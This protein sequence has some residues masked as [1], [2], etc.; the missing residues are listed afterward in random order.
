MIDSV[1]PEAAATT[2]STDADA[3]SEARVALRLVR[4]SLV[5]LRRHLDLESTFVTE[6]DGDEVVVRFL[7]GDDQGG[8]LRV[9]GRHP[10]SS[11][12]HPVLLDGSGPVVAPDL[13]RNRRWSGSY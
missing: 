10:V 5:T 8:R 9:G 2:A 6:H 4:S 11:P 7:D 1:P 12:H 13:R 3:A